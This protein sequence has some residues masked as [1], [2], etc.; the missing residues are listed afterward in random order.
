MP[1][2]TILRGGRVI[3]PAAGTEQIADVE[4]S[5]GRVTRVAPAGHASAETPAD[6]TI[7]DV[8][9]LIVGPGFVDLHSHV[10]SIAG[11]RLQAFDGVTTT[12]DLEAGLMPVEK[13]YADAAAAGR[14][15][16][17]GF[18][19]SW[20]DA[21]GQVLAGLPARAD[22]H[23]SAALLGNRDWQRTST[24]REL[25]TWLDLLEGE[26]DAGALGIGVLIG[27]A[28][29]SDPDEYL[30]VARLAAR[31]GAPTFTHVRDLIELNDATPVDGSFEVVRAAADTGAAM[32]HC[33]VNSTSRRHVDRVLRT[34]DE[35]TTAGSRVSVEAYPYGMGSTSVGA[36]FLSPEALAAT[37]LAPS[38]I[39]MLGTG[40]RIADARRLNEI[41]ALEPGATC[42]LEFL[43]E[44][45]E[46]DRAIL[47]RA[48]E[49]PDAIVA[50]DAM[51]V[52]WQDGRSDTREWPLPPGAS[53]HPRT[54]GTFARSIR[55][56]VREHGLWSWVE[57]FRRA[58]YLPARVLDEVA[59]DMRSKGRL[60]AGASADIV[61]IDPTALTDN[62]SALDPVRP[63]TGVRHLLVD[64]EFVIRD[65]ALDES[66]YPGR[67][68]RGLP[69]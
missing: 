35:A 46:A 42:L 51:P 15:L 12:L 52:E 37:G 64:G 11:Q 8:T 68:V 3:D 50:S 43:D 28:P 54:A 49:Y 48:L 67:A 38:N 19:A 32:H 10:H 6:A 2:T 4:I 33:H 26:L 30:A 36:A 25:A 58:S 34:L 57:A 40:E 17:Y 13:A 14:V 9:G 29:L 31:S 20:T 41:R 45:D 22:F 59:P 63:S 44:R 56:M 69:R 16:H 65:G 7:I 47:R 62:A 24:P 18:S 53:T 61:V 1:T 60:D 66:A 23:D 21:R 27:Y 55:L 39:V 5:A